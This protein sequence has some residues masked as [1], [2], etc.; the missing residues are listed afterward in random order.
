MPARGRRPLGDALADDRRELRAALIGSHLAG[1]MLARY[2]LKVPGAAAA[3][4]ED[5]VQAAGPVVQHYLTGPIT[6]IEP[7]RRKISSSRTADVTP[8]EHA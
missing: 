5:L 4:P 1:L 8:S 2:I 6:G 3:S 7:E